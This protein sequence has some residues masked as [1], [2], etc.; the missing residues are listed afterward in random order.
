M[1]R[2]K[3][4]NKNDN[5][6]GRGRGGGRGRGRGRGGPHSVP[7]TPATPTP[8]SRAPRHPYP[9][10]NAEIDVVIQQWAGPSTVP[11]ASR[12]VVRVHP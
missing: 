9:H 5:H 7:A 12:V 2:G 3:N 8:A 11:G 1:P 4:N 6:R 10:S